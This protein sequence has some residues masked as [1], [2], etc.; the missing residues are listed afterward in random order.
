MKVP[1]LC[2]P[3]IITTLPTLPDGLAFVLGVS[4]AILWSEAETLDQAR[5]TC[6][7]PYYSPRAKPLAKPLVCVVCVDP[8]CLQQ[9][10]A[11]LTHG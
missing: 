9:R 3:S 1:C 7:S 10:K 5:F 8:A 2:R 11:A 4:S 6:C